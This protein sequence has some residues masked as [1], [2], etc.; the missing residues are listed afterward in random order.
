MLWA[1][2]A[3]PRRGE[4]SRRKRVRAD[5]SAHRRAKGVKA[6][7]LTF[8]PERAGRRRQVN[9][10]STAAIDACSYTDRRKG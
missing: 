10:W 5:R 2:C 6:G 7:R 4:M 9:R 8:V 3:D 1:D